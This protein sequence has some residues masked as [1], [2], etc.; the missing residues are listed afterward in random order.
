MTDKICFN[1]NA[2]LI[3]MIIIT[4]VILIFNQKFGN[5]ECPPCEPIIINNPNNIQKKQKIHP[6]IKLDKSIRKRDSDALNDDL[7]APTRRLPRHIYPTE[8]N[9]F[10]TEVPTRG[11]P[12]NYHYLGNMI[13]PHDEKIIK[14]FGRQIYPGSTQYEYY[15]IT[16]D[17]NGAEIKLPIKTLND[18]EIYDGDEI[19]IEFLDSSKGK[20]KLYMNEY[21]RPRYNPFTYN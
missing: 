21:D 12:D 13:R 11:H 9:D 15:G 5:K 18:K 8:V 6:A 17:N 2:F 1:Q 10:I 20:F 16:T 19:D 4:V 14:L 7:S 3:G